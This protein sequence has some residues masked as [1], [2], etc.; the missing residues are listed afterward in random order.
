MHDPPPAGQRAEGDGRLGAENHPQ[1]HVGGSRNLIGR[2]Q[3]RQAAGDTTLAA[4]GLLYASSQVELLAP[5]L[6]PGKV[7]CLGLNYRDH[8]AE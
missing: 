4:Q 2:D 7:V 1:R 6:R 3:E 8:A 5:V